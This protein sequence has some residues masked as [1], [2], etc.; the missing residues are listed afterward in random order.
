MN[1]QQFIQKKIEEFISSFCVMIERYTA[2]MDSDESQKR[3][4]EVEDSLRKALSEAWEEGI[5]NKD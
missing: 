5:K 2:E 1:K 3:I 4:E